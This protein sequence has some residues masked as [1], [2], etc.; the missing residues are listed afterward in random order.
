ML[1]LLAAGAAVGAR[2]L[3]W[4]LM[5]GPAIAEFFS[6][7]GGDEDAA[8]KLAETR[9]GLAARI[10]QSEGISLAKATSMVN[11]QLQ[12]MVEQHAQEAQSKG[13]ALAS[14]LA[15]AAG[16]LML[17]RGAGLGKLA[18][19]AKAALAVEEA[20]PVAA[21]EA[22]AAGGMLAHGAQS[23]TQAAALEGVRDVG[24][25]DS[26]V[27]A[28]KRQGLPVISGK[29]EQALAGMRDENRMT[30][31]F[32][33]NDDVPT[34][35][36]RGA[37]EDVGLRGKFA[38]EDMVPELDQAAAVRDIGGTQR[39]ANEMAREAPGMAEMDQ[40]TNDF[41]TREAIRRL[42]EMNGFKGFRQPGGI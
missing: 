30:R 6:G 19:G 35:G 12:P 32:D 38:N 25:L 42:I 7:K 40:A 39:F 33:P 24:R 11:E 29:Q 14:N 36:Q 21:A 26:Q 15:T 22:K 27:M 8:K 10:S 41:R 17:G 18:K 9:D 34:A 2:V 20:A 5:L 28:S 4:A 3:P 1:P 37:A 16:A 23:P 13:G 31:Q